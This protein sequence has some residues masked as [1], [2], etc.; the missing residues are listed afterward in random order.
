MKRLCETY[1]TEHVS[2]CGGAAWV[3][4]EFNDQN[5]YYHAQF[6]VACRP[7]DDIGDTEL[8]AYGHSEF[9]AQVIFRVEG[10]GSTVHFGGNVYETPTIRSRM[11]LYDWT[12]GSTVLTKIGPPV[13][14]IDNHI[15]RMTIHTRM[16]GYHDPTEIVNVLAFNDAQATISDQPILCPP[17][18]LLKHKD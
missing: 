6:D 10:K 5:L 13:P 16:S 8:Q 11:R 7:Q 4:S 18:D 15:Y 3:I 17:V 14:L 2:G 1:I 12:D 9:V